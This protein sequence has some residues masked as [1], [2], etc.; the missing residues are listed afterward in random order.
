MKR[1][2]YSLFALSLSLCIGCI[3]K[4]D[5]SVELAAVTD[6]IIAENAKEVAEIIKTVTGND[7][8]VKKELTFQ[9]YTLDDE[10]YYKKSST[11]SIKRVFQWNKIKDELAALENKQNKRPR[12]AVLQ[13]YKNLNGESPLVKE[14]VRN[15]Y[16]RVSDTFGVER[17]QSVALFSPGDTIQPE[18][19]G[20]DGSL[21]KLLVSE[22]DTTSDYILVE[23]VSISGQWM[24]NKKYIKE[25]G[26]SVQFNHAAFVDITNQNI[27]T[28]V[29]TDGEWSVRSMNPATTGIHKPPYAHETPVGMFI[30]Q[31]KKRKMLYLRD[32]SLTEI[33][34]FAPYASRFTNGAYIHGVPSVHPNENEIEY[35]SSL[36][37]VPRSHMC[38]RNARSHARFV[39]ENMPT[40][41]SLVFIID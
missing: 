28:M 19:Y 23:T 24:V 2:F 1:F 4:G 6:S 25:I 5:R 39:Y 41:Q 31:E 20:R 26:D 12:W 40:M 34:G 36:G 15:G 21:V 30:I 8:V 13:N 32:G 10:Y 22:Q 27:A 17:Y 3:S 37:S 29:K 11:D 16:T 7:I 14:F 38:V 18:R 35:S 33:G 9:K